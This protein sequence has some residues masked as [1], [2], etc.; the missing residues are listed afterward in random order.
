MKELDSLYIGINVAVFVLLAAIIY[1]MQRKHISFSKRVFAALGLGVGFGAVLQW[2]YG[3]ESE[4]ITSSTDWL[5]I[6]GN[7]YVGLLQM[8]VM[9]LIMVAIVSAIIKLEAVRGIGKI[10]AM[11]LGV[12]VFTTMIAAAVGI[13]YANAFDLNANQIQAGEMELNRG[14]AIEEKVETATT[15]IP[16]KILSLVP[17]NPFAD[18]TGARP[19]STIGVVI[20][21]ALLGIAALGVR[22]KKEE[23]FVTFQKFV[24][25]FYEII[26]YLVKMILRLTPYG[27]L[28]LMTAAVAT[29]SWQGIAY[30]SN[31]VIASYLAL[32][33]MFIIHL[34]LLAV[35]GLNPIHYVKKTMPVLS[36]AFTSRTSAGTIPLTVQTQTK[37]LGVS[38]N[39]ANFA[40]SFGASIGQNGCAGI[41]PAMLAVM[42]APTVGLN[43]L[44]PSFIIQL[45]LIV[46]IS[47]FGVA[48]VGGGA[49]F[50][51]IIVLSAMNLPVGLAGLLISVE[52]LIDMGRTALNVSGAMTAGV[53]SS[54]AL[55]QM[56]LSIYQKKDVQPLAGELEM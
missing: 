4:V 24:E 11:I 13:F 3:F 52:P 29:T 26:L 48:G 37:G 28:A 42:I 10:V 55:G 22:R 6:V 25:A 2:L 19:T 5:R 38:D 56:N 14:Q 27:I 12:L 1:W 7:G 16:Q 15:S 36:F 47:S 21:S 32:A 8:I 33:T 44:E 39:I 34:I 9:P 31:F 49:T 46:A 18:M 35:M 23:A 54:K 17:T 40:A 20:F 50:A 51:A 41:Y 53:I 43:P 30:L 45:V